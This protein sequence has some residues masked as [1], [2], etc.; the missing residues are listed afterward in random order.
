MTALL[1]AGTVLGLAIGIAAGAFVANGVD[2]LAGSSPPRSVLVPPLLPITVLG[3]ALVVGIAA[4]L[5]LA[6]VTER[7]DVAR[8]M[9][10]VD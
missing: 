6:R 2:P 3:I 5:F 9:R 4:S 7:A 10:V 1:G 8:L